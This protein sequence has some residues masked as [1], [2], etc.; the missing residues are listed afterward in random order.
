M[1]LVNIGLLIIMKNWFKVTLWLGFI[2]LMVPCIVWLI[3]TYG[4]VKLY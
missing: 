3:H 2:A 4:L 1:G